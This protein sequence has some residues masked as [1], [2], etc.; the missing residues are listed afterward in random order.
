MISLCS[1]HKIG[2]LY[3]GGFILVCSFFFGRAEE[4]KLHPLVTTKIELKDEPD[5]VLVS[6]KETLVYYS[7]V[8]DSQPTFIP[9]GMRGILQFLSH[10]MVFSTSCYQPEGRVIAKCLINADGAVER[11]EIIQSIDKHDD[12]E[13]ARLLPMMTF[14]PAL[15][16]GNLVASWFFLPITFRNAE[17]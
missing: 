7:K 2:K 12:S 17:H 11:V 15:L 8:L 16:N 10:N 14:T 5:T 6:G 3:V 13:V 9:T 1:K 4:N